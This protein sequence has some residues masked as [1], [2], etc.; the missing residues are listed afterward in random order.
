MIKANK[1]GG[2]NNLD[3]NDSFIA[4]E[5]KAQQMSQQDRNKLIHDRI[6]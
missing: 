2:D 5:R 6:F 1:N 4:N 3:V